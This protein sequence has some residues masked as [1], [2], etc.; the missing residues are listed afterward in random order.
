MRQRII[1]IASLLAACTA[2]NGEP[3]P[4]P[5]DMPPPPAPA[6]LTDGWPLF[7]PRTTRQLRRLTTEQYLASVKTLLDVETSSVPRTEPVASVAGFPAIGASSAALSSAGVAE[8]ESAAS[9]FAD[10]AMVS[11]RARISP[12]TPASIS[13]TDC[14]RSFV[15][16]FG[17]RA[18]RRALTAE[19]I[20]AYAALTAEVAARSDDPWEGV[21]STV[22]A[23]LQSPNFLYLAE[24]GEPDPDAPGQI[25]FTNDEMASRL[26]YFLTGDMP[27]D[28]LL[29]AASR[30]ELTTVAGIAAQTD[31][32]LAKSEARDAMRLFFSVMLALDGLDRFT[33]PVQLYPSYTPTLGRALK[34]E[35]LATLDDAVFVRDLDYRR[36]FDQYDTFVN[37]ELAAFYGVPAPSGEG[38][39][40]ATLP[41]GPRRGLLGQAGV[42]AVH[43]HD[44]STSPTKRGLFVLT[45]ILCQPLPLSPPAGVRI[46]P[47]PTG[48]LTMRQRLAQH[49]TIEGCA[50]CHATMDAVGLSLENFDA[51]GVYRETDRGLQID[52]TGVLGG[53]TYRGGA[54]LG[55]LIAE[56]EATGPCLIGSIYGASVGHLPDDFDR[57]SFAAAVSEFDGSGGRIRAVLKAITTSDGFRFTTG[58]D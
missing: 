5:P 16:S 41:A 52:D 28:D 2:K 46:P 51:M 54:E 23:F 58:A 33:R 18:F 22:T 30:G 9:F 57:D 39:S 29:D 32:L 36:L 6:G 44:S 26:S 17:R 20:D 50:G 21:R 11:S 8:F 34:E 47:L 31:R 56:S 3:T 45:R 7:G 40:R 4:P 19:E 15:T 38:F 24:V 37:A 25:R 42:L 35:T 55:S 13:D 43:D 48:M 49:S 53:T 12:C 1:A 14:F 27:D 10:A